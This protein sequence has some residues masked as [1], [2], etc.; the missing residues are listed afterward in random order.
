MWIPSIRLRRRSITATK[1]AT[2]TGCRGRAS[3]R[4][5]A[6]GRA[7]WLD[8]LDERDLP[9]RRVNPAFTQQLRNPLP[10][11][12]TDQPLLLRHGLD[13]SLHD[14][15]VAFERVDAVDL[16]RREDVRTERRVVHERRTGVGERLHH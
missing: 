8:R 3:G 14:E 6:S 10:Q 13:S 16:E 15:T 4:H 12:T 7:L 5:F 2:A 9:H 11:L 1:P